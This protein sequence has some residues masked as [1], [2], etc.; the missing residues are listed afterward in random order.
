MGIHVSLGVARDLSAEAHAIVLPLGEAV[1]IAGEVRHRLFVEPFAF[2]PSLAPVGKSA[3]KVVLGT[4]FKY[5]EDLQSRPEDYRAEKERIA[6]AVIGLLEKR[7]PGL[8]QQI[9]VVDVATPMTTL[10]FTGNGHGYHAPVTAMARLL[11]T[12]QRLS[13]TLPGLENFY[14]VGQWAGMP[15][16]PLVAAMGRDVV[17]AICRGDRRKFTTIVEPAA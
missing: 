3:L 15:G 11:F 2:D 7:F 9:E 10:R 14:M 6:D 13:Q 16:V 8:R 5:W 4:S 17:R 12:G 1:T